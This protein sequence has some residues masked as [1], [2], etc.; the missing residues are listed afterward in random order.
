[1]D[2][3]FQVLGFW[4]LIIALMFLAG[5]LLIPAAI[6]GLQTVLFVGLG[7]MRYTEKTY[8]YLFGCYMVLAFVCLAY[9]SVFY[10]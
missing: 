8:M 6:F 4:T 2:R 1:M 7:Y 10:I 3:M 9:Y 5:H